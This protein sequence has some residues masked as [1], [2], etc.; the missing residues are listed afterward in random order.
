MCQ[1]N[2]LLTYHEDECLYLKNYSKSNK[3]NYPPDSVR[4]MARIILKIQNGNGNEEFEELP[5]IKLIEL[6]KIT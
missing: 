6:L 4:L 1:K 3:G 5:G 2:A